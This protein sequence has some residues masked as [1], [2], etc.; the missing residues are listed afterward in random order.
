[1]ESLTQSDSCASPSIFTKG[2]TLSDYMAGLSLE[3]GCPGEDP[4]DEK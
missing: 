4:S 2:M 3:D 1:M